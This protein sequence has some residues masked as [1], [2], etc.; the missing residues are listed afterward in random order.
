MAPRGNRRAVRSTAAS[1]SP[2]VF[3]VKAG[4]NPSLGLFELYSGHHELGLL[5]QRDQPVKAIY[6]WHGRMSTRYYA[7]YYNAHLPKFPAKPPVELNLWLFADP[8]IKGEVHIQDWEILV[9]GTEETAGIERSHYASVTK[10]PSVYAM[11]ALQTDP[12]EHGASRDEN[13][14]NHQ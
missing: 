3:K 9:G 7:I 1:F 11:R 13:E 10:H 2:H 12:S 5:T 6:R 4:W 14:P 8:I